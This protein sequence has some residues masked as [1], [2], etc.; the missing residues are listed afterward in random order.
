MDSVFKTAGG[1]TGSAALEYEQGPWVDCGRTDVLTER[2]KMRDV[3][4][5]L[6]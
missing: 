2:I 6:L 1:Y 3:V 5:P 4:W